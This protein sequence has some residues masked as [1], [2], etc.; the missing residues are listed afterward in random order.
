MK[1]EGLIRDAAVEALQVLGKASAISEIYDEIVRQRLY[2]FNTPV[3]EHVLRTTIRR[4]TGNVE[5]TDS[6]ELV[7]FVMVEDEVYALNTIGHGNPQKT[8][9]PVGIKRIHRASDKE[10]IIELM[11]SDQLGVFKE[12]WRLILFAAHV[13]YRNSRREPLK[14][15]DSGKGIDQSTFGNSPV[16][17][18]VMYLISLADSGTAETLS[19]AP[20]SEERRIA[21]FQEYANGGLA[22][23]REFFS[24]RP[25]NLDGL[26]EFIETQRGSGGAPPDLNLS[27]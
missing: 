22:V 7:L 12:I 19:G 17:P 6:S 27:I 9:K 2:V 24:S 18:G 20:E 16:W 4:H 3:P 8:G 5:R 1:E 23:M 13:G 11:T 25:A 21:A 15:V 14:A 10:E 26:I